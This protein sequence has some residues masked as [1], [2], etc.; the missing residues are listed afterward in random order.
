MQK[1]TDFFSGL[2]WVAWLLTLLSWLVSHRQST[3]GAL[4]NETNKTIDSFTSIV[5]SIEDDALGYW[6]DPDTKV[7][8]YQLNVKIKR[9]TRIANAVKLYTKDSQEYPA[10]LIVDLRK[11]CTLMAESDTRPI[12]PHD[13]RAR[14]I[15]LASDKL[16]QHF[17]KII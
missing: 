9:A 17:R 12:S 8:S 14:Q 11:S 5:A 4:R 6:I 2:G 16:Q 3:K 10:E 1:V 7:Q 13:M 15:M